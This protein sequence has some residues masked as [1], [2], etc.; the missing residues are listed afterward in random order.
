[1]C[2][3]LIE[4]HT[5]AVWVKVLRIKKTIWSGTIEMRLMMGT[6]VRLFETGGSIA[7]M[8]ATNP[9]WKVRPTR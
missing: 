5:G 9:A 3:R 8:D 7:T 4:I 1:M 2:H 6:K